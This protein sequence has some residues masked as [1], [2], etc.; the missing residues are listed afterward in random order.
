MYETSIFIF[1]LLEETKSPGD[2]GKLD[3]SSL[4]KSLGGGS[5]SSSWV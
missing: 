4:L 5:D 3:K 1:P 2:E